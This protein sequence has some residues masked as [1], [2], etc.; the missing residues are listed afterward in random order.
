MLELLSIILSRHQLS[1]FDSSEL[2]RTV[3]FLNQ[4]IAKKIDS[5]KLL[6]SL[7]KSQKTG[8]AGLYRPTAEFIVDSLSHL[9]KVI[10]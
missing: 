6:T 3:T 5:P 10:S 8:G 7:D 2:D 1:A 4:F 9:I